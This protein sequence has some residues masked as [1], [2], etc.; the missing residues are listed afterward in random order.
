MGTLFD[1][2][3]LLDGWMYEVIEE[4]NV[5]LAPGRPLNVYLAEKV[6]GWVIG[7]EA[8]IVGENGEKTEV[9]I[10][11]DDSVVDIQP[12]GL[13]L[14]GIVQR[15]IIT[16]YLNRY[17]TVNHIY[18][19]AVDFPYPVPFKRLVRFTIRG[20]SENQV[21]VSGYI[22][23]I[24]IRPEPGMREKFERSLRRVLGTGSAGGLPL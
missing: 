17:D 1:L 16:P 14:T 19:V 13:H 3:P 4:E 18:S 5:P 12:Q 7:A 11:T 23:T 22:S 15:G 20:P 2:L 9:T 21:T 8:F 24:R 10:R 6:L